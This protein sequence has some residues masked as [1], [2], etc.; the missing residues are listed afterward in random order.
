MYNNIERK[1]IV[2]KMDFGLYQQQSMKLM[3]TTELRQAITML[4]YSAIELSNYLKEQQL[5]NPLIELKETGFREEIERTRINV[6]TP[7]YDG[8]RNTGVHNDDDDFSPI[9]NLS[10]HEDGLY[11]DLLR[12]IGFLKIDE[13]L[14]KVVTFMALSVNENGYLTIP[15]E[16]LAKELDEPLNIIE[17]GLYV[18]Q[19]LEPDGV[20]ARDLQECL[21]IQ[22]RKLTPRDL[23]A[24]KV[25]VKHLQALGN[26]QFHKIAKEEKITLE[27][28]QGVFDFIQTLNPKPGALYHDEP[29]TY[30]VPD[31]T[32]KKVNDE[33]FVFLNEQH[34]PKL[35]VNRQY[36]A[37]MKNGESEVSEYM[38]KKYEQF[39]WIK[40]SI[41]QRQETLLKVTN[42]IVE[43]QRDFFEHGPTHIQPL[44]L[45]VIADKLNIHESTVS[46][47]TTNKYV[48]TPRGLFELKYFFTS[49]VGGSGVGDAN[50]SEKVKAL[51]KKIIDHEDKKK[52]LSDQKIAELL[53]NEHDIKVSRRTIAKYR[54][55][56]NIPSSTQRKR[57][58]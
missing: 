29:A 24:E 15:L 53:K 4:Q 11:E 33:Y 14:K 10:R 54:E 34:L 51:L 36:E 21:L 43:E 5:E 45:K 38:Q 52:P 58:H 42:A 39:L 1:V 25:V 30:V 23:L 44:T 40:K 19:S 35:M 7:F 18:L 8:K 12:Q 13:R 27:E 28:V 2:M 50:S 48:Q 3:M 37:L 56:L 9:D 31:V 49:A 32:V 22:L 46:R 55:E 26:K 6:T 17:E 41:E 16:E 47:A 57:F 20:G